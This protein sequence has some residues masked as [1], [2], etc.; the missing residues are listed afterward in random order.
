MT[1]Y[2]IARANSLGAGS[3]SFRIGDISFALV[4]NDSDL[5]LRI[6]GAMERFRVDKGG[7]DVTV[8]VS[9]G[10]LRESTN[11]AKIFDSGSVWQLYRQQ[12]NY[13]FRFTSPVFGTLPYKQACFSPDFTAGEIVLHG[14][15]F[16]RSQGVD[17]LEY[18]LDELLM[19]NLL[20]QGRGIEVHACGVEDSD[21]RGF[22]F[23]GQSGAG[24][25]TTARLWEKAGG[26]QV[27]SDDR[28]IL[29]CLEGRIWMYGTPWH[30]EA[31][32]ACALR[33][34]LAQIFFL[35]RGAKNDVVPSRPAEAVARLLACSFLPFYNPG[36]L[37]FCLGFFQQLTRTVPCG[38]L[39][40]VPD[41]RA[42]QFVR[43]RTE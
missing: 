8:Q 10:E 24:K 12:A 28:I 39:R 2:E 35:G 14:D 37:D 34:P 21:G 26:A 41:E 9:W 19:L 42:V 5:A 16:D 17:A 33:T 40:F 13:L 6:Q 29:R 18:P 4:S 36:G 23:V 38:E 7:A 25:T 27:L 20:A 3:L 30:G 11:R 15:Y 22:L 43:E 31:E 32:L 1:K